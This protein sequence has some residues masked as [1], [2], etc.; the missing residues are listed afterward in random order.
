M[1]K[2]MGKTGIILTVYHLQIHCLCKGF[3]SLTLANAST[4]HVP[5]A[6]EHLTALVALAI[7]SR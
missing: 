1:L 6:L 3:M 2:Q 5:H 7:T 4:P